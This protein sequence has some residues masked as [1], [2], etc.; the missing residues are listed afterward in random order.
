[1][2]ARQSIDLN[3]PPH[4]FT[5]NG[6]RDFDALL[7]T[8]PEIFPGS[9]LDLRHDDLEFDSRRRRQF[10]ALLAKRRAAGRPANIDVTTDAAKRG[11]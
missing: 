4:P 11:S 3:A 6:R 9:V 2:L 10:G 5:A 8:K 7:Q 1:M